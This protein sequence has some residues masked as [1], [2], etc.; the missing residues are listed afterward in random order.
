M[1]ASKLLRLALAALL[2][3]ALAG[4]AIA[5]TSHIPGPRGPI[6]PAG[7]TGPSGATWYSG[8]GAPSVGTGVNGDFYL[9]TDTGGIYAKSGGAWALSISSL[10]LLSGNNAWTGVQSWKGFGETYAAPAITAGTLTIDLSQA[11]FFNVASNA[12]ITT[13]T[14]TNAPAGLAS[15]FTAVFTGNGT[16]YTQS[17][18]SVKWPGG[19][20]PTLT[21]T[22]G[23]KDVVAFFTN[24]GGSTW[25]GLV[26]GQNF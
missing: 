6:G 14:V 9:R 26:V 7:P 19:I 13:F 16:A 22:N 17:W 11:T 1:F 24:D 3:F 23:K 5:Q 12:N 20:A 2:S 4:S 10:P 15:S 25:F 8:S 18:G 21:S